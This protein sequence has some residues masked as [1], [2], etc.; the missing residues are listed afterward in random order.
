MK[1]IKTL[2]LLLFSFS[3]FSQEL[4]GKVISVKDGDTIELLVD[5]KSIRI[6]LA[7][8]DCPE[9]SQAFGMD[10]K[11][12]TSDFCFGKE[13]I[14]KQKDIDK[15]GRIVAFVF[16]NGAELNKNLVINGFA[17]HYKKYSNDANL[18]EF[19]KKA[20]INK[21][22]LWAGENPLE[23]WEFRKLSK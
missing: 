3:A 5:G 10:A 23:P 20:R 16:V 4:K 13:A 7:A 17:W 6:R 14:A 8:I 15:Y 21:L 19:E 2:L 11:K 12:Y 9:K 22:G 1:Q 18:D